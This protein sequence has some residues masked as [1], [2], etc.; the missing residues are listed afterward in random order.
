MLKHIVNHCISILFPNIWYLSAHELVLFVH[1][2][3][4]IFLNKLFGFPIN[5]QPDEPDLINC[6][7]IKF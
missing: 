3:Q 7:D 6:Y 5:T 1:V 4:K 2:L